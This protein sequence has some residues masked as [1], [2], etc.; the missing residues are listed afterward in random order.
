MGLEAATFIASL[1]ETNP[2]GADAKYEG[3]NHLRLI[4]ATIKNTFPGMAGRVWRKQSKGSGYTP[5]LADQ[6]SWIEC[7]ANLTLSLT[8]AATLGNGWLIIAHGNG[9]NVTLDPNGA[10]LV[11]GLATLVV[12]NGWAALVFC[13]GTGFWAF[14]MQTTAPVQLNTQTLT[15][16]ATIAWDMSVGRV[17]KVTLTASGHAMGAPTNVPAGGFGFLDVIQDGTGNR[18]LASWNA[19]F[20]HPLGAVPILSTAAGA[21]DRFFWS[22]FDGSVIDLTMAKGM[23]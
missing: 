2:D 3:D 4:K 13:D 20:K 12:P 19:V 10:E 5:V 23:A 15:D 16:A 7:T 8:A 14:M 11:N 9:G 21:R 6:M 22:S 1:T 17:A 18:T